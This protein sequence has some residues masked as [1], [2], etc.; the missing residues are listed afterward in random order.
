MISDD[1]AVQFDERREA[2][3]TSVAGRYSMRLDPRDGREPFVC[4][5]LDYSVTGAR[6]QLP[7][8]IVLPAELQVIIGTLSHNAR[9]VWRNGPLVGIDF[10]DEH[11]SIF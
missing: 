9:V 2:P 10:V 8:A 4:A 3:R 7:E 5:V 6:L 11:Y 1:L